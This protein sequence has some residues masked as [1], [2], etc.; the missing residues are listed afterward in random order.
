MSK[1]DDEMGSSAP[2]A[3]KEDLVEEVCAA[4]ARRLH[5]KPISPSPQLR[6]NPTRTYLIRSL[7][8]EGSLLNQVN[9]IQLIPWVSRRLLGLRNW[10]TPLQASQLFMKSSLSPS[11]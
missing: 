6:R 1:T 2:T 5:H 9:F 4:M 10:F 7:Q 3:A 11:L 8:E